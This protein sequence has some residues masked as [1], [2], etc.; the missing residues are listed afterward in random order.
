MRYF[1]S[2][3]LSKITIIKLN[4]SISKKSMNIPIGSFNNY[5]TLVVSRVF[6]A[7]CEY[8]RHCI[9][10]QG[11][12]S[13]VFE[14]LR[15]FNT[16]RY[17][18]KKPVLIICTH[19]NQRPRVKSR[20]LYCNRWKAASYLITWALISGGRRARRC[21][22]RA[23]CRSRAWCCRWTR[24][25]SSID[26][27]WRGW[28]WAWCNSGTNFAW[29]RWRWASRTR[30]RARCCRGNHGA[31]CCDRDSL[32][33]IRRC[34]AL[35]S[36]W[37]WRCVWLRI[38]RHIRKCLIHWWGESWTNWASAPKNV[39]LRT[40]VEIAPNEVSEDCM[41]EDHINGS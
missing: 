3:H 4:F 12:I 39:K 5:E 17:H 22:C 28:C 25:S 30:R 35:R 23:R 13:P 2:W 24:R 18:R 37:G 1:M 26:R 15:S 8:L 33:C 38:C 41:K 29:W 34:S 20:I 11:I 7:I 21:R 14:Y 32:W 6:N 27:A 10:I 16:L 9:K 19:V 36:G 40:L 31:R